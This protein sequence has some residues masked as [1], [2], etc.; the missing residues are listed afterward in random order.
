MW[1]TCA[2]QWLLRRQFARKFKFVYSWFCGASCEKA[3][4]S[5]SCC[6]E[7]ATKQYYLPLNSTRQ[8]DKQFNLIINKYQLS[9]QLCLY[10][11]T[12][13]CVC[14]C[15]CSGNCCLLLLLL[16]LSLR[17]PAYCLCVRVCVSLCVC[18]RYRHC[19]CIGEFVVHFALASFTDFCGGK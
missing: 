11:C 14:I 9:L 10:I 19:R 12:C 3:A 16:L 18:V 5:S 15:S 7:V 6:Q 13:V 4:T 1:L 17:P 2:H 8:C